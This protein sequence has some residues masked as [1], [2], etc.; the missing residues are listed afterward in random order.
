MEKDLSKE[1]VDTYF[2]AGERVLKI[3]M[4]DGTILEGIFVSFFLGDGGPDDPYISG[5]HFV[6]VS[7]IERYRRRISIEDM[8]GKIIEQKDIQ[9]VE[10]R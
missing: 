7:E 5:W 3:T 2:H 4:N 1:I 8:I 10:F 9:K 6:D